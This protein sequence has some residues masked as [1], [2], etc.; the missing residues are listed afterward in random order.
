MASVD[1]WKKFLL[2]CFIVSFVFNLVSFFLWLAV[3]EY[4][5]AYA[6]QVFDISLATYNKIVLDFFVVSK[7]VMYYI[8]LVP[9]LALFWMSKC[10]KKDWKKNIS[11]D[12]E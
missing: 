1:F 10:Q 5:F 12:D 7:Y 11:L 4:S 8:F 9:S 2:K 6:H 3:R